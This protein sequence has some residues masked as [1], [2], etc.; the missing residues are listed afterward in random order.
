MSIKVT[1]IQ[2]RVNAAKKSVV[3][4][5]IL[6]EQHKAQLDEAGKKLK[7]CEEDET[8]A[9][10]D[11]QARVQELQK[12]QAFESEKCRLR[13]EAQKSAAF[14]AAQHKDALDRLQVAQQDL[15]EWETAFDNA[16]KE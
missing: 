7:A 4:L 10:L 2:E 3:D 11:R 1:K 8:Q 13:Q 6:T 16:L 14:H 9:V 12:A 5:D 15:Q